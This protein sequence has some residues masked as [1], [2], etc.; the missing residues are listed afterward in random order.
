MKEETKRIIV[1]FAVSAVFSWLFVAVYLIFGGEQGGGGA[2]FMMIPYVLVPGIAAFV[3]QKFIYHEPLRPDLGLYF[4]PNRWFFIAWIVAAAA[5]FAI[6]EVGLRLPWH[7]YSPGMKG[8]LARIEA[9]RGPEVADQMT[10]AID[11]MPFDF[12]WLLVVQGMISGLTI[13]AVVALFEELGFRGFVM[14]QLRGS[15]FWKIALTT[16]VLWGVWSAPIVLLGYHYPEHIAAGLGMM[17]LYCLLASPIYTYFRMRSGSVVA[18]AI[19]GGTFSGM[20][21]IPLLYIEGG[22]NLTAGVTG[23]AGLIVLAVLNILIVLFDRLVADEPLTAA[24]PIGRDENVD[25]SPEETRDVTDY[26]A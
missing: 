13:G 16:G 25:E 7:E 6:N 22:S 11:T 15:G 23:L 20:S 24:V 14:R 19:F 12:F 8:F 26:Q 17:P 2:N 10:M 18:S 3:I 9:T 1:F 21:A 5:I 4:K